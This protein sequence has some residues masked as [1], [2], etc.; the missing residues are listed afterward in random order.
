MHLFPHTHSDGSG[1]RVLYICHIV[2]G[3]RDLSCEGVGVSGSLKQQRFDFEAALRLES[4][5]MRIWSITATH[6]PWLSV[7]L[8][9]EKKRKTTSDLERC[10]QLRLV[11]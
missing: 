3:Q 7:Y 5:K 2:E 8:V 10:K 4:A 9:D 11:D 1:K 6:L